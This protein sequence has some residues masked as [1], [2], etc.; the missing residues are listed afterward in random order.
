MKYFVAENFYFD[1][2]TQ[3]QFRI[4]GPGNHLFLG[5]SMLGKVNYKVTWYEVIGSQLQL[6]IEFPRSQIELSWPLVCD[7][8]TL[9]TYTEGKSQRPSYHELASQQ[10][11]ALMPKIV[12]GPKTNQITAAS[13]SRQYTDEYGHQQEYGAIIAVPEPGEIKFKDNSIE[14]SGDKPLALTIQTINTIQLEDAPTAPIFRQDQTQVTSRD[15]P[16]T[17]RR[18]Y[19]QSGAHIAHLVKAKKTSSFEYGTIFP[20]D[21]IESAQ[22]GKGD[23]SPET[24]D[25]MYHQSLKHVDAEGRGWHEEVIGEYRSLVSE[26][27]LVDRKMI[28]IEPL[29]LLGLEL[30]SKQ[31][32]LNNA[33][34]QRLKAIGKYVLRQALN[35]PL[36][37]FKQ[38]SSQAEG[39]YFEVGNWR[40]SLAA[41]PDQK[42]PIAPY[43][44][45]CVFYPKAIKIL[46]DYSEFFSIE[47]D[48]LLNALHE[49]WSQQK[50]KFQVQFAGG[51]QG[52]C[53][54]LHGTP[55]E[56]LSVAHLD[57]S[58]DLFYGEPSMED[59][60]SF[61][62]R[63]LSEE[64]F[65][66][67]VGPLLVAATT[68]TLTEKHYHGKVIWPKQAAF[69]VAG[70]ARQYRYGRQT[71]WPKVVLDT[72]YE[73]IITTSEASFQGWQDLGVVTELYYYDRAAKKARLYIDQ[74]EVE[75]QMSVIQLW[76]AVACRRIVREYARV[77]ELAR[78]QPL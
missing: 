75:G 17:I 18:L 31:F 55:P 47:D 40:D 10:I 64:Y 12:V 60:L 25:Y 9:R 68:P 61:A 53:L 41:F 37:T 57:E 73:A 62:E 48:D 43:D 46:R 38:K 54:A 63:I 74:E 51:R 3:N 65:Y 72:L 71:S 70:L 44:V 35:K 50:E 5:F 34:A 36:I 21:W 29:Y 32:I 11:T 22:L 49:K 28:D 33:H 30:V 2:D 26:L 59:T 15:L 45:N 39:E 69:A 67:P 16:T 20:R 56:P 14:I 1:I 52:Y 78:Q 77:K 66:T 13:F 8:R 76:S 58:Y 24:I 27:E 42:P 6:E 4:A 23:L 19:H 7:I